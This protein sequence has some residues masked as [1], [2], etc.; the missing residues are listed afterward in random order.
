MPHSKEQI[1]A[2]INRVKS[3]AAGDAS[4]AATL[5]SEP[6]KAFHEEGY[7]ILPEQ[8]ADFGKF[9]REQ[10]PQMLEAGRNAIT[11]LGMGCSGCTVAAYAAATMIGAW[12]TLGTGIL[13]AETAC[14]VA[15]VDFLGFTAVECIAFIKSLT[16]VALASVALIA[17]EICTWAKYCP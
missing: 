6:G 9:I 4:F 12:A 8:Y 1:D 2:I 16:Y 11:Q 13:T 10:A 15:L 17:K 7:P 3:R 14:V 5:R